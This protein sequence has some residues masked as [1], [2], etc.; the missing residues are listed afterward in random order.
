MNFKNIVSQIVSISSFNKGQ[1]SKIFD[2]LKTDKQIVVVKNNIPIAVVMSVEEYQS[3][4]E[5]LI[6]ADT[7]RLDIKTGKEPASEP[8][9]RKFKFSKMIRFKK[10]KK[11]ESEA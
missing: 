1:A 10:N 8:E 2:R 9:K 7:L 5:K 3:V 4:T 11:T 6:E